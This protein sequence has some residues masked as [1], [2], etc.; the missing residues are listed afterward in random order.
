MQEEKVRIAQ[1]LGAAKDEKLIARTLEFA[2]SVS[3]RSKNFFFSML[4][5]I[6]HIKRELSYLDM[7][8]NVFDNCFDC[9]FYFRYFDNLTKKCML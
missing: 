5:K 2:M 6:L 8:C 3:C 9:L 7:I 1:L 4:L